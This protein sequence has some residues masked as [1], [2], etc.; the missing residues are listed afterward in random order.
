MTKLLRFSLLAAVLV[1]SAAAQSKREQREVQ[2]LHAHQQTYQ[3]ILI[4]AGCLDRSVWNMTRA[5][6]PQQAAIAPT[7]P[8]SQP[9]QA[10]QSSGVSVDA[11]TI[12]NERADIT[13]VMVNND[14]A[15]RQ[16][17]PTCAI[18]ANTRGYALL[19]SNGRLLDLDEG[20]NTYANALVMASQQGRD[21]VNGRGPGFKPSV[22]VVGLQQGN[23]LFTDN[24]KLK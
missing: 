22:T 17:D 15:A 3:G 20:G 13:A 9:D 16:S 1:F 11:K 5:A 10:N 21:M 19:L 4:D 12:A 14:L 7:G 2:A 6:E 18:K 8:G 23:R 24:L